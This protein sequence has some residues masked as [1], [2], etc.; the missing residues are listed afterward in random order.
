MCLF[1]VLLSCSVFA[2]MK[3]EFIEQPW[4][5]VN[6]KMISINNNEE[7]NIFLPPAKVKERIDFFKYDFELTKTILELQRNQL[8][9]RLKTIQH[10]GGD[11]GKAYL[12]KV[13]NLK[14]DA[15][16]DRRI[17]EMYGR[18]NELDSIIENL[19]FYQDKYL[20]RG[21]GTLTFYFIVD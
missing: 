19:K 21:R 7:G 10:L 14:P 11:E 20:V 9:N 15:N 5:V 12:I 4:A 18:V 1:V 17:R 3:F 2:E 8:I 16:V 6:L 13:L